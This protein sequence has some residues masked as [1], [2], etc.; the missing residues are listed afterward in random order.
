MRFSHVRQRI[1][2]KYTKNTAHVSL[3]NF[4]EF[5]FSN[6]IHVFC[7]RPLQMYS[8]V[9]S[10]AVL[11]YSDTSQLVQIKLRLKSELSY[12]V[13]NDRITCKRCAQIGDVNGFIHLL[14]K[15]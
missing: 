3:D 4:S 5:A 6:C 7:I 2:C 12:K 14:F 11:R 1:T 9:N 8:N 15:H 10:L 13:N